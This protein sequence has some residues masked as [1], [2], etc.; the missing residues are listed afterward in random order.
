MSLLL[1]ALVLV[2]VV[3]LI[4]F[5]L[6]RKAEERPR[7]RSGTEP[8]TRQKEEIYGSLK[9][10]ELDYQMGKLSRED[11]EELSAAYRQQAL[12]LLKAIDRLGPAS[13]DA[14]IEEEVAA[15]RRRQPRRAEIQEGS[16][17]EP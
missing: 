14:R 13:L 11:Y 1:S 3:V 7:S 4:F 9:D 16:R 17:D 5:P 6:V 12:R 8:L 10:I 2:G 15:Y